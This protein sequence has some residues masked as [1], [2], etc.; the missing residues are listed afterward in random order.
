MNLRRWD[1]GLLGGNRECRLEIKCFKVF[2]KLV[3]D[4]KKRMLCGSEFQ[5]VG[6][7]T[8][9]EREPKQRLVRGFEEIWMRKSV[10]LW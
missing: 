9:K 4:S 3:R 2:P 8:R 10:K 6:A 1:S 5:V 7:D